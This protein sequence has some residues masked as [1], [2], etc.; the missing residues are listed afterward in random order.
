MQYLIDCYDGKSPLVT[1]VETPSE[2][3]DRTVTPYLAD[4]SRSGAAIDE[5][6]RSNPQDDLDLPQDNGEVVQAA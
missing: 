3:G 1:A 2:G 4:W 5:M 6:D